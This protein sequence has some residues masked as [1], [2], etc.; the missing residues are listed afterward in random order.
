MVSG[1]LP[2][3]QTLTSRGNSINGDFE[4]STQSPFVTSPPFASSLSS[5]ADLITLSTSVP[6]SQDGEES[7]ESNMLLLSS[8][9]GE[10]LRLAI[11]ACGGGPTGIIVGSAVLVALVALRFLAMTAIEIL[12]IE[13]CSG[14]LV[15]PCELSDV[16]G[17]YER[18]HHASG[19]SRSARGGGQ[20][21]LLTA[22][23]TQWT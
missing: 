21:G 17:C 4:L 20:E 8:L 11:L 13:C 3:I 7:G 9:N 6:L 23:V 2:S 15:L 5:F 18:P 14:Y 19:S 22:N 1:T 10:L 16:A 12:G